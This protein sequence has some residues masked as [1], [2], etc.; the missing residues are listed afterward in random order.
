MGTAEEEEEPTRT[1]Q[2]TASFGLKKKS[3]NNSFRMSSTMDE[4]IVTAKMGPGEVFGE[5]AIL[6]GKPR[7]ASCTAMTDVQALVLDGE[8]LDKV[9]A[10]G[11]SNGKGCVIYTIAVER[12]EETTANI[13]NP[14]YNNNF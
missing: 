8:D 3:L 2:H 10:Q 4:P 1:L 14:N 11:G 5:L 7:G 9:M 6:S 12:L 13:F